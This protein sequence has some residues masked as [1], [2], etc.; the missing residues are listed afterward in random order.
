MGRQKGSFDIRK[1]TTDTSSAKGAARRTGFAQRTQKIDSHL[2]HYIVLCTV[3]VI[4]VLFV[5][6][7]FPSRAVLVLAVGAS[8]V[9]MRI[10]LP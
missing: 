2:L 10:F 7:F 5:Y 6:L 4:F 1:N 3:A 9:L 8:A